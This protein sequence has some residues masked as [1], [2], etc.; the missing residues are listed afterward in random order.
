MEMGEPNYILRANKGVIVPKNI[1]PV[2]K[3][4]IVAMWIMIGV[5]FAGSLVFR[6]SIFPELARSAWILLVLLVMREIYVVGGK[7]RIPSPFEIRFYDDYLVI[8]HEFHYYSKKV[9]RMEF[10][11]FYYKDISACEFHTKRNR[12]NF[13]GVVEGEWYRYNK[14]GSLPDKPTY[15]K[16]T[17]SIAYFYLTDAD[18]IDIIPEIEGHSPINVVVKDS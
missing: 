15:H 7:Y 16:T 2:I 1:R 14:D 18:G 9:S 5:V 6:E 4:I 8:Y 12:F 17:D 11:K 13:F 3:Y 10:D